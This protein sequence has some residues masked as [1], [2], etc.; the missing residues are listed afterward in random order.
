MSVD[1][2]VNRSAQDEAHL[3]ALLQRVPP[4]RPLNLLFDSSSLLIGN[5][6]V[7][8]Y[9]LRG[10]M[11]A[12]ELVVLVVL[13]AGLLAVLCRVQRL[14]VPRAARI[15]SSSTPLGAL[16][17]LLVGLGWLG[18][19][20]GLV[21]HMVFDVVPELGVLRADPIGFV[22]QP[23]ILWPLLLTL[24]AAVLDM[25]GDQQHFLS[26][27]GPF[28]STVEFSGM[29]RLLTLFFGAIPFFV[30]MVAL[31]VAVAGGLKWLQHERLSG[32]QTLSPGTLLLLAALLALLPLL[33][34]GTIVVL[35][36]AGVAGWAVGYVAAKLASEAL[37]VALPLVLARIKPVA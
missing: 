36:K 24:A 35:F 15:T 19:S 18:L 34:G 32:G 5:G 6:L 27:G 28:I 21:F 2:A 25:V 26:H 8:Y 3:A 17:T 7:L 20:Y 29:A 16:R 23:Q 10:A 14:L 9:L 37:V 33:I 22:L 31:V 12:F 13:E 30:P 4:G 11:T 1:N